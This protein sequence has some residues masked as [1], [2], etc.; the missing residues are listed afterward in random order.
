MISLP[1]IPFRVRQGIRIVSVL[2]LCAIVLFG[3]KSAVSKPSDP[4]KEALIEKDI[5]DTTQKVAKLIEIPAEK[6]TVATITDLVKVQGQPFFS[7]AKNADK[8]L[9]FNAA[10]KVI[11]YR[12]SEDK[13]IN[14]APIVVK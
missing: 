8:V 14:V 11:L 4:S 1:P 10:K 3:I 2:F 13:I 5:E 7:S 6:P 12:P 9:F